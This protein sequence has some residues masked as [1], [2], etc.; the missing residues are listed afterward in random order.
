MRSICLKGIIRRKSIETTFP[1]RKDDRPDDLVNRDFIANRPNQMWVADFTLDALNKSLWAR[2]VVSRLVSSHQL[3]AKETSMTMRWPRRLMA[4]IKLKLSNENVSGELLSRW[5]WKL[6][7]GWI[8][9][10]MG[11]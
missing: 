3:G 2:Q 1:S 10:T 8:C 6:W 9:T 5:N 11:A 4:S 7:T